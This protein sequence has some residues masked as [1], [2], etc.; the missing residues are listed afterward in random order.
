M[1]AY[2]LLEAID[3]AERNCSTDY[4]N[5][6]LYNVNLSNSLDM[7]NIL[8]SLKNLYLNF[9]KKNFMDATS[10]QMT[11]PDL[12][13][14]LS[15]NLHKEVI[16]DGSSIK[17]VQCR[18]SLCFYVEVD[19]YMW[20]DSTSIFFKDNVLY[21]IENHLDFKNFKEGNYEKISYV[22]RITC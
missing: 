20:F 14:I 10:T 11:V 9:N 21:R 8:I 18:C 19:D 3:I 5:T 13:R 15:N 16:L 6:S 1:K 12:K 7:D 17:G 2:K 22:K 4:D